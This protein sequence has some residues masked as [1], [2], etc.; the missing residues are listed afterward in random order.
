MTSVKMVLTYSAI[1]TLTSV[2]AAITPP[3][4]DSGSQSWALRCASATDSAEIAMPHGLACLMIAT[5]ISSWSNAARHA[6]SA[7]VK[8]LYD[9]SFPCSWSACAKPGQALASA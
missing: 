9:I 2:F 6:A 4:A 3:N 1:S 8:L 5:Q 7:S